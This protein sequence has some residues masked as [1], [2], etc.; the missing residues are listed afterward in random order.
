MQLSEQTIE[1]AKQS[2]LTG[3]L[4][5]LTMGSLY[6]VTFGRHRSG[7]QKSNIQILRES[8]I[9]ELQQRDFIV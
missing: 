9:R 7:G 8:L 2:S 1:L 6:Y 4:V 5:G 3:A